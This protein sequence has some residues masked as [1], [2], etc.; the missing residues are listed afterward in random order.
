MK[1]VHGH[2]EA[3]ARKVTVQIPRD[4]WEMIERWRKAQPDEPSR[5]EAIRRL[6]EFIRVAV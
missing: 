5:P 6:V 4:E 3:G 1:A 2:L